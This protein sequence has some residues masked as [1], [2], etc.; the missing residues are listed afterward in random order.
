MGTPNTA[1]GRLGH[2]LP[3]ILC[4]DVG[5]AGHIEELR[6]GRHTCQHGNAAAIRSDHIKRTWYVSLPFEVAFANTRRY[7]YL[8][9]PMARL[10]PDPRN[11]SN[12]KRDRFCNRA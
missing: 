4:A 1:H 12:D 6:A 7:S 8:W 5:K 10:G 2:H 9:L 3:G 11:A